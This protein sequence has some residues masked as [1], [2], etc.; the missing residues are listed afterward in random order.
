M[1]IDY[2]GAR[3]R[4]YTIYGVILMKYQLLYLIKHKNEILAPAALQKLATYI[5]CLTFELSKLRFRGHSYN[6]IYLKDFLKIG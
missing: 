3:V 1:I 5:E 6:I 2:R 4:Y